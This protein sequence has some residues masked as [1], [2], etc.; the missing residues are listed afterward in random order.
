MRFLQT[1]MARKL[2]P[3][4]FFGPSGMYQRDFG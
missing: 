4:L 2:A 1:G 3:A